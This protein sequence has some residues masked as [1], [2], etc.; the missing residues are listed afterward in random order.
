MARIK[1]AS[2]THAIVT[3]VELSNDIDETN[4]ASGW[5]KD[6]EYLIATLRAA[7]IALN[8]GGQISAMGF[9]T[10]THWPGATEI[11]IDKLAVLSGLAIRQGDRIINPYLEDRFAVAVVTTDYVLNSDLPLH[12]SAR[13]GKD[14]NYLFGLSGAV[15]GMERRRRKNRPSHLG[16]YPVEQ[17]KRVDKLTTEVFEDEVPR[18]PSRANFYVRS[19]MGDLSK[20][21]SR[22]ANRWSQKHPVSQA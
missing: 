11:D 20:K 4:L 8:L 5:V 1:D 15:S 9:T 10:C 2:H 12:V 17:L 22:E 7:E 21:T 3:L 14:L 16:P 13:N 19:A 6:Y 18:V